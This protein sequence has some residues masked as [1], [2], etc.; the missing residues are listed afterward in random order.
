MP[1]QLRSAAGTLF[2]QF[3]FGKG[4]AFARDDVNYCVDCVDPNYIEKSTDFRIGGGDAPFSYYG[5][6]IPSSPT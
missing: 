6:V 3:S 1:A 2:S 5:D 4:E